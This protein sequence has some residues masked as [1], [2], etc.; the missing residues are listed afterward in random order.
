MLI[1]RCEKWSWCA[2]PPAG[3][4]PSAPPSST[5]LGTV[6]LGC[7]AK[8]CSVSLRLGRRAPAQTDAGKSG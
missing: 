1:G 6:I 7:C 8:R 2:E 5:T 4:T 3:A